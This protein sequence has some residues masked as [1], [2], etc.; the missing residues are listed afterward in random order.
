MKNL[1]LFVSKT[2]EDL[3]EDR[4]A[5]YFMTSLAVSVKNIYG[6]IGKR[7]YRHIMAISP[8]EEKSAMAYA[9]FAPTNPLDGSELYSMECQ[10]LRT[11]SWHINPPTAFTF[12]AELVNLIQLI[13]LD[14]RL[15]P[16]RVEQVG[17]ISRYLCE[18]SVG[19]YSFVY[20]RPSS[21]AVAAVVYAFD[22]VGD[23]EP[24]EYPRLRPSLSV[25]ILSHTS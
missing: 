8:A 21:V 24:S 13:A 4:V 17:R 16:Q 1:Q 23:C 5:L 25:Q 15:S 9:K 19:Q 11:L 6:D 12:L 22:A 2:F 3:S 10:F 14:A 18:L 7:H 20:L